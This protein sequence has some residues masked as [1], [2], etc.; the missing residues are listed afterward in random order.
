[1]NEFDI[2]N[3]TGSELR[4]AFL[5]AVHISAGDINPQNDTDTCEE[6]TR[7][8]LTPPL[9][10]PVDLTTMA[11]EALATMLL[12]KSLGAVFED[13]RGTSVVFC[14]LGKITASGWD[15]LEA[16]MR[17]YLLSEKILPD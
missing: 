4:R 11:K 15:C 6:Q 2:K 3:L 12:L 17:A 5:R 16:G 8:V 10:A 9:S 7:S 1:M 13:I 14:T